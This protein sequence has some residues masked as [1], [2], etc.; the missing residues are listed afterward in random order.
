M[1]LDVK[2]N[3]PR[4]FGARQ[5]LTVLTSLN[6]FWSAF[7]SRAGQDFTPLT[8]TERQVPKPRYLSE[9]DLRIAPLDLVLHT[10]VAAIAIEMAAPLRRLTYLLWTPETTVAP[11]KDA[12]TRPRG[13]ELNT[14]ALPLVYLSTGTVRVFLPSDTENQSER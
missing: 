8:E 7:A 10:C 12:I 14:R 3:I 6:P 5:R 4:L 9:V 1:V 11:A 2:K 13:W